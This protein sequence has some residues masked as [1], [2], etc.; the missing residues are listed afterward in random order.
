M[1]YSGTGTEQDPYL[2]STLADFLT[3][4]AVDGA[5][6]KVTA[7]IDAAA[8]ENYS[9]TLGDS[10]I[11]LRAVKIYADEPKTISG[12][13]GEGEC[14]IKCNYSGSTQRID[15]IRFTDCMYKPAYAY[16]SSAAVLLTGASIT[17]EFYRCAVSLGYNFYTTPAE[18][19]GRITNRTGN[20]GSGYIH[21]FQSSF[22]ITYHVKGVHTDYDFKFC[23]LECCNVILR[24]YVQY[25]FANNS[26]AFAGDVAR[27]A[28]DTSFI[29]ENFSD[30][31]HIAQSGATAFGLA[32]S[33]N[34]YMAFVDSDMT[35][36]IFKTGTYNTNT[37]VCFDNCTNTPEVPAQFVTVTSEQL[38]S[39]AYLTEIGFLP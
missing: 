16:K 18:F 3:C 21:A 29:C 33:Q 8:D 36:T 13:T 7:D 1:A 17:V 22:D 25:M 19:Q 23:K 5:F 32:Y 28:A 2:V 26:H 4:A 38:R 11:D 34:C 37:L 31:Y 20:S 30:I 12:I 27:P 9:G 39:K 35:G 6:V 24:N 14:F 10:Y 15:N